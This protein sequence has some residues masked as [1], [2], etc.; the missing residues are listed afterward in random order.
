MSVE[1]RSSESDSELAVVR[2]YLPILEVQQTKE[3]DDLLCKDDG[4]ISDDEDNI[5]DE[6][7]EKKSFLSR[8]WR[9]WNNIT[10]AAFLL[11]AYLLC[12][13]ACTVIVPFFPE[14]VVKIGYWL[15]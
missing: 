12:N 15:Q 11:L 14:K 7:D 1:S 9:N 4:D 13:A 3:N 2:Q 5:E 8:M 6:N 10:I